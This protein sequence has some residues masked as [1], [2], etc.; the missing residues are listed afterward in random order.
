MLFF[1]SIAAK[2]KFI[3]DQYIDKATGVMGTLNGKTAMTRITLKPEIK[4]SDSCQP[5]EQQIKKMH[6]QSHERCF[7]ANSVITKIIIEMS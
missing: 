3:V 7:I 6:N 4:F 2:K 5:N 1:L